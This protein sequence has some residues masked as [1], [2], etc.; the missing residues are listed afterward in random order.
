MTMTCQ[1]ILNSRKAAAKPKD[2]DRPK[3]KRENASGGKKREADKTRRRPKYPEGE[4]G[5]APKRPR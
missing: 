1:E 4:N 2:D 3:P 5:A